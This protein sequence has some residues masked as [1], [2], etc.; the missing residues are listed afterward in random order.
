MCVHCP[1]SQIVKQK[2][3]KPRHMDFSVF[4]SIINEIVRHK[5]GILRL[6]CDGEP[7]MHPHFFEMLEYAKKEGISPLCVNTNGTLLNKAASEELLRIGVDIVEVS[8]DA[9]SK[10]KYEQ[11]RI[12]AVYE[13]VMA[14]V[15]NFIYL[16]NRTNSRTK[17]MVSIIDQPKAKDEINAFEEFWKTR[18]DRVIKRAFTSIGGLIEAG[19]VSPGK[20]KERWPCP[21]LWTRIFINVDGLIKFCVEDWL[22]KT[23][24]FDLKNVSIAS[25]WTS[26]QYKDLRSKHLSRDFD[27]VDY[28]K[29]CLDWPAREWRF[30][31][32]H[33]LNEVIK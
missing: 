9:F 11:I 3:Y 20:A 10:E 2:S 18:S 13:D 26:A 22:D 8:L 5:G 15:M 21:L 25:A 7:M 17:I 29:G 30:D 6:V 16:R 4:E 1:H 28:C 23:I 24:L 31:Y 32:F 33:A 14:N 27:A 12:G 19:E